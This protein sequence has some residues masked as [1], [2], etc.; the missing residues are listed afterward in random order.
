VIEPRRDAYGAEADTS[1][2]AD[3]LE[4]LGLAGTPLRRAEFADYLADQQWVVRSR[5]LFHD[6]TVDQGEPSEDEQEGGAGVSPSDDAADHVFELLAARSDQLG[7]RYPF[8]LRDSQLVAKT[9]IEDRHCAYLC[10]LAITVA[11]HYD[12]ATD[13][14]PEDVFEE[15]VA[16]VMGSRG[17]TTIGT[18]QAAK[19]GGDFRKLVERVGDEL[20]LVA[21][22][23]AASS[24][25]S[26]RDEGVDA[27]SYLS[28]GD[29][30]A[31]HWVFVGQ[32]TC[33]RSNEWKGKIAEPAPTQWASLLNCVVHPLAYLAV[34]H[35]VEDK[36]L[37]HLSEKSGRLVLD[38]LRLTRH[39]DSLSR[40]QGTLLAAVTAEGVYHP[41]R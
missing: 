22:P 32:A 19:G 21:D 1:N 4:L 7:D 13:A 37:L 16:D 18:G 30:R 27:V 14:T 5:E 41:L 33:A 39:L 9:P 31:G 24:R 36:H 35:H 25:T 10:L 17:L 20:G 28:W 38:R 11:H 34:P 6:P 26:A 8:E 2:L 23:H 15:V 12:V 3:Y 29:K 40:S